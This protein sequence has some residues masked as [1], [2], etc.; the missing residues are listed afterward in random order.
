M[1][2][3]GCT[4]TTLAFSVTAR[5]SSR[6]VFGQLSE[7]CV[8]L[9][10]Q[11][12]AGGLRSWCVLG[13]VS[14]AWQRARCHVAA[15]RFLPALCK[16]DRACAQLGRLVGLRSVTLAVITDA[17]LASLA[18]LTGLQQ[19][20]LS[21]CDNITDAGLASLAP[22]TG[23][24]QLG[25]SRCDKITDVGLAS[26]APLTG[27]QQLDLSRCRNITD[28][29]LASLAPLTGL[30]QLGL[31]WCDKITDAGLASLALLTALQQ[32][33]LRMCS[34]ITDAGLAPLRS[35]GVVVDR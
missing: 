6:S 22:L 33:D 8:H 32:L 23:L 18:P 34:N 16:G 9:C 11:F 25:L 30:Q 1:P 24:Q 20:D 4:E 7:A 27:L 13:Q 17:G 5:K 2:K 35:F 12:A 15:L 10:F 21:E 29:G 28:A 31:T 14:Q 3:R 26:L 19:L